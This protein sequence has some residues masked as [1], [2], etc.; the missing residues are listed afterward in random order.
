LSKKIIGLV[1]AAAPGY[2]ETFM[3]SKIKG[4]INKGFEVIVF[5]DNKV[6]KISY[7]K[8]VAKPKLF[9][10]KLLRGVQYAMTYIYLS[11]FANKQLTMFIELEKAAGVSLSDIRR[12]IFSS[13]HILPHRLD[14]LHFGFA[15]M[16][17]GREHIAK[18]IGAK[19]SVSL[20]GYDI[21][22]YP[23]KHPGVYQKLWK[24]VDKVHTISDD[25]YVLALSNGLSE[26]ISLS[27]ISPAIDTGRFV[28]NPRK[29]KNFD[30]PIILTVA[31]LHWK[32]G[33]E[34]ALEALHLLAKKG[35]VFQYIIV[36]EGPEREKLEFMISSLGLS[37]FV[38]LLGKRDHDEVI[39]LNSNALVYLQPSLQEGFCNAVLEAQCSG[40][41]CV[42]S[43][44]EG[45][46]ENVLD[47]V[48]GWVVPRRDFHAIASSIE[49]ILSMREDDKMAVAQ[50]AITRVKTEF[51]L[52][53]QQELFANFFNY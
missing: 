11:L 7:C 50:N 1:L 12:N 32:K 36:G 30:A 19:M 13:A 34:Y 44:A 20:R 29:Y 14:F 6:P 16:A 51:D 21:S 4:L 49:L 24:M 27:K 35:I 42:V 26:H 8:Q 38:K 28:V 46:S 17:V 31:R 53:R 40:C 52:G 22:I 33:L 43:D 2:S 25:L 15:T 45:L 37:N 47:K 10:N 39:E 5:C 23:I 41:L 3:Q 9:R 18:A 48:T